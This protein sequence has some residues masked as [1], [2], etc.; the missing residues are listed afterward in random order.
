MS[1]RMNAIASSLSLSRAQRGIYGG[2]AIQRALVAAPPEMP[3]C[4]R[5]NLKNYRS[6]LSNFSRIFTKLYGGHGP[7]YKNDN[8]FSYFLAISEIWSSN[9]FVFSRSTRNAAFMIIL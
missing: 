7:V 2:A 8:L 3:R 1:S 6:A 5:H 9:V 4:A